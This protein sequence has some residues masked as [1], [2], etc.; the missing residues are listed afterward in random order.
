MN[1]KRLLIQAIAGGHTQFLTKA[2][3]MLERV[4]NTLT[5]MISNFIWGQDTAPRIA[6]NTLQRPLE[7][8]GLNIL[9][10][11]SRNKAIEIIW[12]KSYLNFSTS[13]PQW[14]TVT[15]HVILETAPTKSVKDTIMNPFLQTWE[16]PTRGECQIDLS[17]DVKRMLK[18]AK[19]YKTRL[20]TIRIS[21]RILEQLP[22]WYH[23]S[24]ERMSMNNA[25]AR[26]LLRKHNASMVADLV[27]ISAR[28]RHP[29]QYPDHQQNQECDCHECEADRD[30]GC[31]CPHNCVQEAL[32]RLNL[33]PAKHN[34]TNQ[35]PPDGLLLTKSEKTRNQVAS[36][37][38]ETIVFDTTITCK[39]NLAECFRIFT[40][41]TKL[42]NQLTQR[43]KH[44]GPIPHCRELTVY[45]D[46]AC[47]NNGKLNAQCGSRVW[48]DHN[49]PKNTALRVPGDNQSNQ[50]GE[51]AVIIEAISKVAPYQPLK[52]I[53]DSKYAIEGLTTHLE[54]W[55]NDGWIDI[56]NA[57][58]FRKAAHLLR[59]RT[60]KTRFQW[61]KGHNGDQGNEESDSLAKRGATKQTIDILDL[62]IPIEFDVQGAKL[63]TLMQA[64]AY[65]GILGKKKHE[66]RRTTERNFQL[67]REVIS[68]ITKE[69]ETDASIWR[70]TRKTT[71][72]P[73]IQQFLFRSMHGIY[74]VG[75]Y[76]RNIP[77]CKERETCRICNTTD[78]MEHA[79][80][81]CEDENTKK[82]WSLARELQYGH[83]TIHHGQT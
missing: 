22:A 39:E 48:F 10:I 12:L 77:N 45:T 51:L 64:K 11:K 78:S 26:C 27:R 53:T 20:A 5:K 21:P 55:E 16:I 68:K 71:I 66:P 42:N 8:G 36:Q 7:E 15:D 43:Y 38:N 83:I 52:I 24:A 14:A 81:K 32:T 2:Q 25:K 9:D 76:W 6:E 47:M 3:G 46:G 60:A 56:K 30:Q 74:M 37:N 75:K 58:L 57:D 73:L 1:G 28:I 31:R 62:E 72:R 4:E 63:A 23:L 18:V 50:V 69:E 17:D 13:H 65:R 80:T 19:K 61:I 70:G 29:Q 59:L 79:L 41:P 34:P 82:I 35:E 49:N 44:I 67:T 54:N 40:D 33:I